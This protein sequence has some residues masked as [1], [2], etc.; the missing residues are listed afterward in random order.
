[1]RK[2]IITGP[3]RSGTTF[4]VQLLTRLGLDTGFTPYQEPVQAEWRAGCEH[5]VEGPFQPPFT[6]LTGV[7]A[8]APY[9]L[10]SPEWALSLKA[11]VQHGLMEVDHVLIPVRDLDVAARSR[12][13]VGLG[14]QVCETDDYEYQVMD[15]ASVHA[16]AL[17]RAL[18]ACLICDLPYTL[19]T[20]PRL[21]TDWTYCYERVTRAFPNLERLEFKHRWSHLAKPEQIRWKS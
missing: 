20:F 9:I 16:L 11:F 5:V 10:K 2:V 6:E 7:L 14:W 13:D 21:V 17:G 8:A 3:G 19:L 12:L 1:V 18:E 4:L 15:Q